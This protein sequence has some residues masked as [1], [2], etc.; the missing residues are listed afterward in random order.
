MVDNRAGGKSYKTANEFAEKEK[1]FT[2]FPNPHNEEF[3]IKFPKS[4]K[5][6]ISGELSIYS[7]NGKIILSKQISGYNERI[8]VSGWIEGIYFIRI[9]TETDEY[10][11]K[12]IKQ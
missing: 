5:E 9:V 2:I 1:M 7:S 11:T 10:F 12:F 4:G 8:P 3:T 6:K